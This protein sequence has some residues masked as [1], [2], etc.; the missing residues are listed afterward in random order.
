MN[1]P[2]RSPLPL[3]SGGYEGAHADGE[4]G[5]ALSM[6]D[7]ATAALNMGAWHLGRAVEKGAGSGTDLIALRSIVDRLVKASQDVGAATDAVAQRVERP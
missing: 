6:L 7:H 3:P 4:I 2:F 5:A 1:A